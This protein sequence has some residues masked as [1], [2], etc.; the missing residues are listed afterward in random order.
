[1]RTDAGSAPSR[2]D[3]GRRWLL[4]LAGVL[5]FLAPLGLRPLARAGKLPLWQP[6]GNNLGAMSGVA[7][8]SDQGLTVVYRWSP[9]VL[10]R[11]LD[12]ARSWV[13]IGRGLPAD[14]LGGPALYDLRA[15]SSRSL[16]ALAG[17]PNRRGLYRSTDGGATF[18][19]LY[20]PLG[21]NPTLL[22]VRPGQDGDLIALAGGEFA[23]IS[24]DSGV[25][26]H[27]VRLPGPV[28]A[29]AASQQLWAAG[30]GWILASEDAGRHWQ[31]HALPDGMAPQRLVT[32]ERGPAQL[33]ALNKQSLMRTTDA[34]S[35]WTSLNLPTSETVTGFVIDALIWQTLYLADATGGLWRSDD[36]ADTWRPIS[37]PRAGRIGGLFQAPGDRSRIY[38]LAGFDLWWLP[39]VPKQPT[40]TLTSTPSPTPTHTP[41]PTGTPTS[42]S[43]P[44]AQPT[45][46]ATDTPLPATPTA[47][48]RLIRP[49]SRPT[50]TATPTSPTA[51]PPV[52]GSKFTPSP[53]PPGEQPAPVEP[54][55][56]PPTT[57]PPPSTPGPTPYR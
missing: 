24:A 34:G 30:A 11:S 15:G 29:L 53:P 31:I 49:P 33:F 23:T 1:M 43:T 19:L 20:Q 38:A 5:F 51:E 9:S 47:P 3:S 14:V 56:E 57:A 32:S 41:T 17:P 16:F 35:S 45:A 28:T 50:A 40:A 8:A 22:A 10:L 42:T 26:W 37:G 21:L 55:P 48:P 18:E 39:Q 12:G 44:T 13:A 6:T 2:L 27:D 7:F 25:T 54:S 4:W 36:W 52:S 46:T